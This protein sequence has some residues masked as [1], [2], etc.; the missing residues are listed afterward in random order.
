MLDPT[1]VDGF[2]DR[3]EFLSNFHQSTIVSDGVAYPSGEAMFQA[4]K[5]LDP[6]ER[7]WII[8]APT[9]GVAKQRGRQVALRDAWDEIERYP[10]MR[11]VVAAKFADPDLRDQLVGTGTDLLVE[12]NYWHDQTWG[13]CSCPRHQSVPGRNLL[14][15][16]LMD[17][18]AE[19]APELADQWTRVALTGHR[20]QGLP[21]GSEPW[22]ADELRR[23][24]E[25]LV[26]AHGMREAIS[27]AAAGADLLWS[28]AANAAGVPVWLYQP[29]VGHDQRWAQVWRDRLTAARLAAAR[30]D[31]LGDSYSVA[32][33]HARSDWMI[34]DANAVVSVFDPDRRSGGTWQALQKVPPTTPLIHVDVRHRRTTLRAAA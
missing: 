7:R 22:L 1:F 4:E 16:Y 26:A 9:P 30:V 27:G 2:T 14:G 17:H 33:L 21:A 3:Y 34:R 6:A 19:L 20:P 24:V 8:E 25:K 28:E 5:T 12:R 15:R 23:I 18:R 31:T 29:Y 10:A 13:C 32:V 11:R